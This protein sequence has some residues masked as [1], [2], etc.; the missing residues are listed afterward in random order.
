ML[1]VLIA[2]LLQSSTINGNLI[3]PQGSAAPESAQVVLLPSEYAKIFNADAQRRIDRYWDT[4]KPEFAA[5]K[6]SFSRAFA[7]AYQEAL[8]ITLSHMRSDGKANSGNVIRSANGG[9][10][11]FRAVPPGDYKIVATGSIQAMTYVWTESLQ[12][13][14]GT[15]FLQMKNR[16]P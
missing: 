6:E 8:E 3:S 5:N 2:L 10:F 1:P 15:I 4:Y 13:T 14:S 16:V 11:E 7:V 9:H 12:V